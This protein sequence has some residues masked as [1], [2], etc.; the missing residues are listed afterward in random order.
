MQSHTMSEQV[1]LELERANE[2]DARLAKVHHQHL[3]D[4]RVRVRQYYTGTHDAD[5]HAAMDADSAEL[6]RLGAVP[7][8]RTKIGR[9]ATCPCGSGRKFKKCCISGARRITRS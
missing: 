8:I 1:W 9:N 6:Q 4:G 7:E 5:M 2:R 3:S